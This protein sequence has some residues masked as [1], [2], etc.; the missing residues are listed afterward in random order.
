MYDSFSA[1][2]L[3]KTWLYRLSLLICLFG[4][5][6]MTYLQFTYYLHNEDLASISYPKFNKEEKDEYPTFS[7]CFIGFK[8]KG[9]LFDEFHDVFNSTN[10]TRK[11][12]S[13]Y[14]RGVEN[15]DSAQFSA[16][17]FDDVALDIH[18]GYLI[19]S[20]EF[21]FQDEEDQF[22]PFDMVPTYQDPYRLCISKNIS[23]R[24]NVVQSTDSVELNS[25]MLYAGNLSAEVFV[26]Q[27]G[28]FL[29][30]MH[31]E[32]S[33]STFVPNKKL[34]NGI[35]RI[36]DIGQTE[37]LRKRADGKIPCDQDMQDEDEYR[38]EQI[39]QSVGCIPTFWTQLA[40]STVSYT[41]LTLATKRIV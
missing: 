28:K 8:D 14:L 2:L 25:S 18:E 39:I 40:V 38:I 23:H 6:Y 10:I 13:E 12:Y 32:G 36:I 21:Y 41:H 29:R 33:R 19:S 34:K 26:H 1:M 31:T 17:K 7:I 24:E 4:T 16:I 11:S 15:Y 35:S 5:G 37:I 22:S 20:W 27:K 30:G 3:L 9:E